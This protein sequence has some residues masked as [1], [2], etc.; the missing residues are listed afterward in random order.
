MNIQ[1]KLLLR[2]GLKAGGAPVM[3]EQI[4]TDALHQMRR[5]VPGGSQVLEV[6]YGDGLLSC[7]LAK[8]L[9]WKILGLDISPKAYEKAVENAR[10][11]DLQDRVKFLCCKPEETCQH[12][13][14]YDAVFIKTVIYNAQDLQEYGRWLDWILSV[15]R[16]QGVLINFETG[17]ANFLVQF[18][19]KL[20]RREYTKLS[21]YT[22]EIETLYDERFEIIYRK[23]YAGLSQFVAPIPWLY[24]IGKNIESYI[25]PRNANNCFAVAMICK[26]VK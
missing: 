7:Y 11:L 3:W 4:L 19:R 10:C 21:L 22:K 26:K 8:E 12:K 24:K 1:N 9:G 15:L 13:G 14:Q 2:A 20:R 23:Y 18:Y 6:G 17:H 5:L 25:K 16:P